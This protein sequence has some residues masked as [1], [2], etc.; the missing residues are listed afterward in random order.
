[1]YDVLI[2]GV[3]IFVGSVVQG[4]AG[5]AFS[6]V[7]APLLLFVLSQQEVIPI[8]VLISMALNL[9]VLRDC[10]RH[11]NFK[12]I[13]PIL[14][15]GVIS[16]PL[17]IHI[18]T[19]LDPG[20]FKISVGV[21]IVTVALVMMSGWRRPLPPSLWSL[22]PI[23]LISGVLNGSLSM[24]G[25]PVVLFLN[26][27]GT[28]KEE[29]R[30]NLAGYFLSLNVFTVAMYMVKGVMNVKILTTTAL[31]FP[32]LLVGTWI[33]IKVSHIMPENLF[34]KFTLGLITITGIVMVISNV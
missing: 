11:L 3:A 2:G 30:A 12:K 9:M 20:L 4:C 26:N 1:M 22:I 5:F 24:S 13:L 25:P 14:V 21:F 23:G 27:Q 19:V 34:R 28:G 29:F 33:G 18:L 7:A 17:G 6:L 32:V 16:L 15:G 10:G 31:Y 8:L